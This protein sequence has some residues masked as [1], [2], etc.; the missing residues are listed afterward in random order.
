MSKNQLKNNLLKEI[1]VLR[2]EK[3]KQVVAVCKKMLPIMSVII[4]LSVMAVGFSKK[5]KSFEKTQAKDQIY[6]LGDS[7]TSGVGSGEFN[8]TDRLSV[9]LDRKVINKGVVGN[10]SGMM[11]NRLD[12]TDAEYVIVWGGINDIYRDVS[13]ET[14][15]DNLQLIYDKVHSNGGKVIALNITPSKGNK[16]WTPE[17]QEKID[18]LNKWISSSSADYKIDVYALVED[19][20]KPDYISFL[21][22]MDG[23]H[24]HQG[25]YYAVAE[26]INK[27]FKLKYFN[28]LLN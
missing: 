5:G 24:L 22:D 25:G 15:K 3:L 26:E 27:I 13:T 9:L 20:N 11:L 7:L 16:S 14:T 1:V 8:Y 19:P 28:S 6:A 4:I 12:F 21:Y 10:T 17:K 23:L 18:E 2:K